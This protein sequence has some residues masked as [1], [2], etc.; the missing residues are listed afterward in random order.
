MDDSVSALP[1]PKK[2]NSIE[3]FNLSNLTSGVAP[4]RYGFIAYL[5][6][7]WTNNG[8]KLAIFASQNTTTL[9]KN[10]YNSGNKTWS[11]WTAL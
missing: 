1:I 7:S 3:F 10:W 2:D 11:G 8:E 5:P 9:Y 4:A 6:C